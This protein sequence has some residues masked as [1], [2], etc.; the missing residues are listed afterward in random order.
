M[1]GVGIALALIGIFLSKYT[2]TEYFGMVRLTSRPYLLEGYA[3]T[4]FGAGWLVIGIIMTLI[5]VNRLRRAR[6]NAI[7]NMMHQGYN[8]ASQY[9]PPYD[10]QRSNPYQPPPQPPH[11]YPAN[12]SFN[13]A[14][15][16]QYGPPVP[17][18]YE[19]HPYTGYQHPQSPHS[20]PPPQ[21]SQHPQ[22]MNRR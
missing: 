16:H 18:P 3:L 22:E 4:I 7:S 17:P 9:P 11:Q 19:P 15:P 14:A 6:L 12:P 8:L 13:P 5:E 20:N 21:P 2:E 10:P 1:T